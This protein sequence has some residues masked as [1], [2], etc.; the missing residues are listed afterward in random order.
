[1]TYGIGPRYWTAHGIDLLIGWNKTYKKTLLTPLYHDNLVFGWLDKTNQR[2][3][4]FILLNKVSYQ[5]IFK[6][7]HDILLTQDLSI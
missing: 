3:H 2:T 7:N 5:N 6:R 4:E 1:M